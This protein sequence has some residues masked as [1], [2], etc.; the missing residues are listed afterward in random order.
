MV[1]VFELAGTFLISFAGMGC[2]LTPAILLFPT[3][4]AA[5][6]VLTVLATLWL[7]GSCSFMIW[8]TTDNAEI[9]SK[10]M[11]DH[12]W[13]GLL[14]RDLVAY[15]ENKGKEYIVYRTENEHLEM[16]K[17]RLHNDKTHR[18]HESEHPLLRG[19]A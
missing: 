12:V 15:Y 19:K 16:E 10:W 13:H 8:A 6:I 5:G 2:F 11:Y 1:H 4:F 17:A 14:D 7:F 3:N 18:P 9:F